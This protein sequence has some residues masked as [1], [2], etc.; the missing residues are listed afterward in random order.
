MRTR[1]NLV[2]LALLLLGGCMPVEMRGAQA[3]V[4]DAGPAQRYVGRPGEAG[5]IQG[6]RHASGAKTVRVVRPGEMMTMDYRAD[7]MT[8]T[9]DKHGMIERIACG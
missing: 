4:C 1:H 6:A 7:R 3:G 9:V 5:A 2:A 8:V